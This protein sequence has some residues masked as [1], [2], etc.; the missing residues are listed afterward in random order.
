MK[1]LEKEILLENYVITEIYRPGEVHYKYDKDGNY[2]DEIWYEE[3]EGEFIGTA[4]WKKEG[5]RQEFIGQYDTYEE[6]LNDIENIIKEE[7]G[8]E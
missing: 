6:A 1:E 7:Q 2:T 5:Y 3:G 4:L 8:E